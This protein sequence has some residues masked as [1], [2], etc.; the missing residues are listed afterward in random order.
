RFTFGAGAAAYHVIRNR[1]GTWEP[2]GDG[3][4]MPVFAL[5]SYDDGGGPAIYAGGDFLKSGDGDVTGVGKWNGSAWE[6]VGGG[7]PGGEHQGVR[8]LAV[9][10]DGAG[11]ALYATGFFTQA[12]GVFVNRVARW[13]GSTWSPLGRGLD[14]VGFALTSHDDGAGPKL[15]VGGE[16]V[17][18]GGLAGVDA[19]HIACWDGA[20]WSALGGGANDRVFSLGSFQDAGGRHLLAG[21]EFTVIGGKALTG[22]ARWDGSAWHDLGGGLVTGPFKSGA[23]AFQPL[24]IDGKAMVAVGG[25]FDQAGTVAANSIALWSSTEGWRA[26]GDGVRRDMETGLVSA[27]ELVDSGPEPVLWAGGFF[28]LAGGVGSS[29]VAEWTHACDC[30]AD[31]DGNGVLDFFDFLCFQNLFGAGDLRADCD[32]N[33]ILDFFDFLCFQ[34]EFAKGC[35]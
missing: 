2:V 10:D 22:A 7:V 34:N 23:A 21:G 29:N 33:G 1:A 20:A 11:P 25:S 35:P 8:D 14:N 12:G 5:A 6:P 4:D 30:V 24:E 17:R 28:S 27:I 32:G 15:Y 18:A 9:H 16:F 19:N 3:F 13:D 31:C 26:L